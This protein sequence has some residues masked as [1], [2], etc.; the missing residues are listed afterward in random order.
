LPLITTCP[1]ETAALLRD[2][3]VA[4]PGS[5]PRETAVRRLV[6]GRQ[7]DPETLPLLHR[8]AADDPDQS[9]RDQARS[10]IVLLTMEEPPTD[11]R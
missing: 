10:A 11:D 4:D 2:R 7:D 5:G 3:A 6:E 9:L 1:P 8:I